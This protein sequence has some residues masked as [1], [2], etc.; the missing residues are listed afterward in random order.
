MDLKGK[1]GRRRRWLYHGEKPRAVYKHRQSKSKSKSEEGMK[2]WILVK[3]LV[4]CP[5]EMNCLLKRVL[6]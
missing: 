6:E 1:G 2:T 4:I 5:A 3:L